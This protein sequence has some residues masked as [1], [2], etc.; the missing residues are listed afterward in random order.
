M[1]SAL[2]GPNVRGGVL[3]GVVDA[4]FAPLLI[5]ASALADPAVRAGIERY[6]GRGITV[7]ADCAGSSS[8]ISLGVAVALRLDFA[9]TREATIG[10]AKTAGQTGGVGDE[11]VLDAAEQAA[12]HR[13][14]LAYNAYVQAK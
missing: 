7:R 11:F 13:A 2:L 8:F 12:V 1:M 4:T 3:I 6:A 14:V 5:P 10:C 9:H